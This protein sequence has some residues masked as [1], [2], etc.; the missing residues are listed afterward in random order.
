MVCLIKY[1]GS[2]LLLDSPQQICRALIHLFPSIQISSLL[3]DIHALTQN[4]FQVKSQKTITEPPAKNVTSEVY[5]QGQEHKHV[6]DGWLRVK[7][8]VLN[9]EVEVTQSKK[10]D[11]PKHP[12]LSLQHLETI[13]SG[14]DGG[15]GRERNTFTCDPYSFVTILK[16][17]IY[18][19]LLISCFILLK[20][21]CM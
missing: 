19:Y 5:N 17:W 15:G 1:F 2:G 4:F 6:I 3:L 16:K 10:K 20:D 12:F 21:L 7:V 11:N 13:S 9:K 8:Y 14:S 18:V